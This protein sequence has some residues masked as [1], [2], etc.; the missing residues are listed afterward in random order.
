LSSLNRSSA[1]TSASAT[2]SRTSFGV[3]DW[4][5]IHFENASSA[6]PSPTLLQCALSSRTWP[7]IRVEWSMVLDGSSVD[8]VRV[9]DNDQSRVSETINQ[10]LFKT[11]HNKPSRKILFNLSNILSNLICF[12][13]KLTFSLS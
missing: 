12:S 3:L 4:A 9:L 10:S 2:G 11:R 5:V 1:T 7:F 8:V 6:M 13:C